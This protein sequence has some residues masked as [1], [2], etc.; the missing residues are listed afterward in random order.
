MYADFFDLK[1]RPFRPNPGGADVFVGPQTARIIKSIR[2]ALA[3]NDAVIAVTGDPGVGKTTLVRRSLDAL[4]ENLQLVRMPRAQLAHDEVIDY[5]LEQ[6]RVPDLPSGML[7]KVIACR[8][9]LATCSREGRAVCIVVEDAIR[10]GEDA[11]V[12]LEALTASDAADDHGGRLVLLGTETLLDTLKKPSLARL[13]QRTRLRFRVEPLSEAELLAYLKHCFRCA[14]GDYDRVFGADA[15]AML[16]TLSGGTP[17]IANNLVESV[18]EAAAER[19]MRPI[20]TALIAEIARERHGMDVELPARPA[21]RPEPV[22]PAQTPVAGTTVEAPPPAPKPAPDAAPKERPRPAAAA[23]DGADR[24]SDTMDSGSFL[25]NDTLPDL[26]VIAPELT[27]QSEPAERADEEIPTLFSS[28]RI[29]RPSPVAEV[30]APPEPEPTATAEAAPPVTPP[31]QSIADTSTQKSLGVNTETAAPAPK[32]PPPADDVPAWDRDPTLAE[33]RPDMEALEQAMAEFGGAPDEE[34][35][36]IVEEEAPVLELKNTT[37]VELP[38]ITLDVAIEEKIREAQDA[39][40]KHDETIAEEELDEAPAPSSAASDGHAAPAAEN[41]RP[42]QPAAEKPKPP[43]PEAVPVDPE[44]G[45]RAADLQRLAAGIAKAKSLED[46]DDRMAE[47]LF[48]EDFNAIAAELAANAPIA[49]K[50]ET[51]ELELVA[52][53]PSEPEADAR[54]ETGADSASETEMEREFKKV[55]G[56]DALEVSLQGDAPKA[57]LDL[58][59]SQRLATVRALNAERKL[60]ESSRVRAKGL[61]NGNGAASTPSPTQSIEDQINTSMTQ[62]LRTLAA[63]PNSANDD[64]DD[65]DDDDRKGGFFSRFR[66]H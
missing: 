64:D 57:G 24:P 31:P 23:P 9:H 41:A 3:T 13:A 50:P 62:T 19:Q 5:L 28:T 18:V 21:A 58:S 45:A 6:L 10:I 47:T 65:D 39:L 1:S 11:L 20:G 26:E 15:T 63:R 49:D 4:G 43:Q 25:I 2:Q 51:L 53:P 36:P 32:P 14:G 38:E 7:R 56:E 59:A 16:Y 17:R 42:E 37:V 8:N 34:E 29:E 22:P 66:R 55:Y 52:D 12:E 27:A 54:D 35:A 40:R 46:V 61:K 60:S 44:D 33:L 48:G 30:A